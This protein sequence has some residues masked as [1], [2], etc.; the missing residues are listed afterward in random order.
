MRH[1]GSGASR[2]FW[3]TLIGTP[4]KACILTI[5]SLSCPLS[6]ALAQSPFDG[7]RFVSMEGTLNTRDIGGYPTVDG[8][9][10]VKGRM[11]RSANLAQITP[12]DVQKLSSL[13]IVTVVDFRGPKEALDDPDH[14]PTGTNYLNSPIV[15]SAK[16]DEIDDV[17]IAKMIGDAGLPSTM[18]D[19]AKVIA[20]GPYYRI[21]FLVSSYGTD[22]HLERLKGYRPLFQKLLTLPNSSNI[23]FHCT[24]GRDRTG[25]GT[26]LVLKTL[27]V[28]DDVIE[29]DF[30]ASNR[31]LQPD[32]DNPDS[33]RFLNFQSA[34]VFLQPSVNKRYRQVAAELGAAPDQLRGA[35]ELRPELLR[36]MFS[37]INARYGSFNAFL[38]QE[39]GVGPVEQATLRARYTR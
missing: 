5:S 32:R 31:Y 35:V 25:V 39:M 33:T 34:N 27:G 30:V 29:A 16:G 12:H 6:P 13:K 37:A 14:L 8:R 24:G 4:G 20:N 10:V 23:L 21:L 17:A 3:S 2:S 18:L 7:W 26:A 11:F 38:E 1:C 19:K 22:A 36:R 9:T 15:G 28:P